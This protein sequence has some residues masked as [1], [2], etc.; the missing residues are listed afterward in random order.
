MKFCT[1]R[2]AILQKIVYN[3]GEIVRKM[4][5]VQ[6]KVPNPAEYSAKYSIE[7]RSFYDMVESVQ[8]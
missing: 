4:H 3:M 6:Q 2:L 7:R 5:F 1:M 8:K